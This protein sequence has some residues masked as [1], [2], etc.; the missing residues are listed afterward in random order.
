MKSAAEAEGVR[1]M[2]EAIG[3]KRSVP[4]VEQNILRRRLE[5][6]RPCNNMRIQRQGRP[7][8]HLGPELSELQ[9]LGAEKT[10][11]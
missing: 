6:K 3:P 7:K 8:G 4:Q 5:S 2:I 1:G 11:A 9:R 10:A